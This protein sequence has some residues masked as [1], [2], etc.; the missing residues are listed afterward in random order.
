MS[1]PIFQTV[2]RLVEDSKGELPRVS[3]ESGVNIW[4]LRNILNGRSDN[5]GVQT[6]QRLLDY[7]RAREEMVAKLRG[8]ETAA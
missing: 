7:F 3:E 5:P 1:E 4:T 2:R 6:C 8:R